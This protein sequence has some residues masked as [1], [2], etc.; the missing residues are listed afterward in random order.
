MYMTWHKR[1]SSQY[2]TCLLNA[3]FRVLREGGL[4]TAA[5]ETTHASPAALTDFPKDS[6]VSARVYANRAMPGREITR[7]PC[8]CWVIPNFRNLPTFPCHRAMSHGPGERRR[9]MTQRINR[10]DGPNS[11]TGDRAHSWTYEH[12]T[13]ACLAFSPTSQSKL[14]FLK[15]LWTIPLDN[16]EPPLS[17]RELWS[18]DPE[19]FGFLLQNTTEGEKEG[20]VESFVDYVLTT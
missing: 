7:E 15:Y 1:F 16:R 9:P 8:T 20:L 13:L 2:R 11:W 3:N 6:P 17:S 12:T 18:A 4:V 10:Y 5:A 19:D 14:H